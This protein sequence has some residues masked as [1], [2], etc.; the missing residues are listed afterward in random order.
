M[1]GAPQT[2]TAVS[3]LRFFSDLLLR[4]WGLKAL[5]LVLAV[6]LFVFTRDEVTRA[7]T[8]PLRVVEDPERV[9]MTEVPET[10][11]ITARGPWTRINRLQDYDFGVATLDLDSAREGP[12]EID[13]GGIVMPAGVVLA[14]M[15]YD[16]V[17]LRFDDIVQRP[18]PIKASVSGE[19]APDYELA[20]VE[21]EP[22][23]W[24]VRGGESAVDRV[25][26]LLTEPLDIDGADH[27]VESARPLQPLPPGLAL[28][29]DQ[30]P[31]L[32]VRAVINARSESRR[33]TVTVAVPAKLD[34]TGAIPRTY[35]TVV[36]GPLPD[37]RVVDG[38]DV[39]VPVVANVVEVD[40]VGDETGEVVEVRFDWA[41]RV[42][43]QLRARLTHDLSP[44]RIDLPAPPAPPP[45]LDEPAPQ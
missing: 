5:A 10:I 41:P 25:E 19:V 20:R 22:Q 1:T 29:G 26:Q 28:L 14:E 40:P 15:Q 7:F 8:V 23:Q 44:Q 32:T 21:V 45:T 31:R 30:V 9:L 18:I 42:P 4:N 16:K 11:T 33:Y 36:S 2:R 17:D 6:V 3:P 43:E 38:L 13:R 37:F 27:D 34:P 24:M 12:L 39:T 35:E